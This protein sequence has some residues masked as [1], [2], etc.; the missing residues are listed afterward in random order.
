MSW[1]NPISNR[2]ERTGRLLPGSLRLGFLGQPFY[3]HTRPFWQACAFT[4]AA[5]IRHRRDQKTF[6]AGPRSFNSKEL[7]IPGS[8]ASRGQPVS[9]SRHGRIACKVFLSCTA[10]IL[11]R[12]AV[13][14]Q[15]TG[16]WVQSKG[17]NP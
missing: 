1:L 5:P 12:A 15:P 10:L 4:S 17:V 2:K 8:S 16:L 6:S 9:D 7:W 3:Y 14:N 11:K 13:S